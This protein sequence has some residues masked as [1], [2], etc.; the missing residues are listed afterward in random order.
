MTPSKFGLKDGAKAAGLVRSVSNAVSKDIS[1]TIAQARR[2]CVS[3]A[4]NLDTKLPSALQRARTS[5]L[6]FFLFRSA[7]AYLR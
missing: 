6:W 1:P 4:V 5:S 7:H 3:N 2:R